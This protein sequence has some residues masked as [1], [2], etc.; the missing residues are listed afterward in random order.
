MSYQTVAAGLQQRIE[1][2]S[3][4]LPLLPDVANKV[5]QLTQDPDSTSGQLAQLIQSDQA[6][7]GHVMRI[8]NSAAYSPNTEMVSLQ[9]A[10]T[11]LGMNLIAE[12]AISATVNTKMFNAPGQEK[13]IA[14]IWNHA[15][16]SALWAKEIARITRR[17]VEATFLCALLH[18]IGRPVVLQAACEL[19][20][21][22]PL[23]GKELRQLENEYQKTVGVAVCEEW[24]MPSLVREVIE[25]LE[26]YEEAPNGR[27]QAAM[28]YG[29]SMFAT[30]MLNPEQLDEES[31]G[32]QAVIEALNLYQDEVA[33]LLEKT[34]AIK[35]TL[36][37][38]SA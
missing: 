32:S 29:A 12:I 4:E 24:G 13:H 7:A 38:M 22:A 25:Y 11:R 36:G 16:A 31:L 14:A 26:N 23:N 27:D 15:L 30:H 18:G 19:M 9:Q 28:V 33:S 21:D 35:G 2:K 5:I 34:D 8:A 3:L 1:D 17:N 6:L 20:K 37:S 10:I